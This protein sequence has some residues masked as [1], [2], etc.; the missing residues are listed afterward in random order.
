VDVLLELAYGFCA[1]GVRD[2]LAFARVFGTVP[3][4]EEAALDGDEGVVIFPFYV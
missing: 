4:V 3:R 1:E 2:G